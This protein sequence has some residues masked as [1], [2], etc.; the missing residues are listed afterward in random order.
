MQAGEQAQE[1]GSHAGGYKGSHPH[2]HNLS[3]LYPHLVTSRLGRFSVRN[4]LE[5]ENPME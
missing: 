4:A 2:T 3:A 5:N 1:D